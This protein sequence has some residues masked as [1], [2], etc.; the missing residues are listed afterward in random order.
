MGESRPQLK[1]ILLVLKLPL[2]SGSSL[3]AH[4]APAYRSPYTYLKNQTVIVLENVASNIKENMLQIQ[5]EERLAYL[6]YMHGSV[7]ER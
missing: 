4:M 6:P 1:G 2:F 3:P 7:V 5:S